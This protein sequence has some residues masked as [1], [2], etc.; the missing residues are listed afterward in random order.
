MPAALGLL[1]SDLSCEKL[2]LL[3]LLVRDSRHGTVL[4][5]LKIRV[6]NCEEGEEEEKVRGGGGGGPQPVK[7]YLLIYL[8]L[9]W[10]WCRNCTPTQFLL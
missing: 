1:V 7:H 2:L 6:K 9:V 10:Q 8:Q 4:N 3:L 5:Q